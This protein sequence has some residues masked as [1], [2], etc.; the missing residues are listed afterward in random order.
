[1]HAAIHEGTE[2]WS[3]ERNME[4]RRGRTVTQ[5]GQGVWSW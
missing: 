1:M 2:A 3:E 5:M 4:S